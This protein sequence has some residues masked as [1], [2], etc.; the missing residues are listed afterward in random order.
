MEGWTDKPKEEHTDRNLPIR[1]DF[2]SYQGLGLLTLWEIAK[3][4]QIH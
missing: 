3:G 4:G 1:Q 2:V